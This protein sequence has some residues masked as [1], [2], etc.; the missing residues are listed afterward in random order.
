MVGEELFC[1]NL[2]P[3]VEQKRVQVLY[4]G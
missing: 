3:I 2:H 1:F 4:A